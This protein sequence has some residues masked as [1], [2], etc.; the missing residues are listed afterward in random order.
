MQSDQVEQVT[1]ADLTEFPG[2]ASSQS[3]G[4]TV[5]IKQAVTGK[6]IGRIICPSAG[7]LCFAP[8]T[9]AQCLIVSRIILAALLLVIFLPRHGFSLPGV[10]H[11]K[12]ELILLGHHLPIQMLHILLRLLRAKSLWVIVC[13]Q[14]GPMNS[15]MT[16]A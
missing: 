6:N 4:Q 1:A 2:S 7:A 8:S 11:G 16:R 14:P 5:Q 13:G 10:N 12:N 9:R 15:V 3:Q